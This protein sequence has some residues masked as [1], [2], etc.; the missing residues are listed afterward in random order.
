MIVVSV[1]LIIVVVLVSG[2]VALVHVGM[3]A[4]DRHDSDRQ[5]QQRIDTAATRRW[6]ELGRLSRQL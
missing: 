1:F 4:G 5:L 2:T 6:Q 3:L